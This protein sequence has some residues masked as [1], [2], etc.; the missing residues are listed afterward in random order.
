MNLILAIMLSTEQF[1]ELAHRKIKGYFSSQEQENKA[2]ER[3]A[4]TR[5]KII[6]LLLYTEREGIRNVLDYL[7]ASGFYYRASSPHGHH[8][9]PGGLAE[10]SLGTYMIAERGANCAG[11]AEDSVIL[12]ALLHDICKS[13]R[14]WFRG[15]T[16]REHTPRCEMDSRHSV[17][18]LAILK[19][20][21]LKLD[22]EE[23]RAIRWH[24]KGE[25]YHSRDPKLERDHAKA[26]REGVW[27]VVF[28]ADKIDAKAHPA[29]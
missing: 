29:I 27:N 6:N 18:S 19:S 22:P 10:H 5:E 15:K 13:D 8:N 14:F 25:K 4:E 16:I 21:G 12:A 17:R 2:I 11:L 20:C 23:R 9:Y 26:V 3:M 7:D 1:K 24:M 28:Y